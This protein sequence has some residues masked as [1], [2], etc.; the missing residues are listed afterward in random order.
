MG[1]PTHCG[2]A[3]ATL[4]NS[5]CVNKA[6]TNLEMFE[7][8]CAANGVDL[9]KYNRTTRGWQGRL[10]M[11]GRNLLAKRV[12]ANNCTLLMPEGWSPEYYRFDKD[13]EYNTTQKYKPK[14][15]D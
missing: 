8:I 14:K 5:L 7:Q 11:T 3:M 12:L 2:D 10:R 13:W 9:S 6:G 15:W 4:L 1:H